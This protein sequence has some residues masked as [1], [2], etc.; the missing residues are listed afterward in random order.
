MANPI[1]A[2][3]TV[4]QRDRAY[5][6]CYSKCL[7]VCR[8]T[9]VARLKQTGFCG[10]QQFPLAV[11]PANVSIAV[12]NYDQI[13]VVCKAEM[14]GPTGGVPLDCGSWAAFPN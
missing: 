8:Q 2:G 9:Q 12:R 3:C 5:R 7:S 10:V 13:A 6:P 1:A 4:M 14:S 11:V